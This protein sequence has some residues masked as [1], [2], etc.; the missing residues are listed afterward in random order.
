V[1]FFSL[2]AVAVYT[3]PTLALTGWETQEIDRISTLPY[4][5]R[6]R[7]AG[8]LTIGAVSLLFDPAVE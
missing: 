6:Y 3:N 5:E 7:I 8:Y 4:T 1:A 2:A